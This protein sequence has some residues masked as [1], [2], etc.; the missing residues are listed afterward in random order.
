MSQGIPRLALLVAV[1]CLC[2][3]GLNAG[4]GPPIK[5]AVVTG[6]HGFEEG[7]FLQMFQ[8]QP[9]IA[10]THVALKD[11]SEIFERLDNWPYDVIVLYN[12]SQKISESRRKNFIALLDKGVGLVVL[13]HAIGAFSEW[14]EYRKIVGAKYYLK[15]TVED[16]VKHPRSE[17]EHGVDYTIHV[18]D[19]NH[20]VTAGVKDFK[21]N[22]ETYQGYALEPDNHILLTTD[23]PKCQKEVGWAR[24][25][26]NARV[27]FFQMGHGPGSYADEDYRRLVLQAI[28]WTATKGKGG[29]G[30]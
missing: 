12:M 15:D 25:Y 19:P 10:F 4:A 9:D 24:T 22:D 3:G 18:V 7:P 27:C 28:R 21:I 26:H 14:P 11:D 6:G 13:H 8:G 20:A 23:H 17:Y 30:K 5:V 1:A 16:G 29:A 2:G